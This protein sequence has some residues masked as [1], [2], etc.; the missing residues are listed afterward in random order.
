MRIE[1]G[2]SVEQP[3]P[4]GLTRSDHVRR[5]YAARIRD[6]QRHQLTGRRLRAPRFRTLPIRL[7]VI[8]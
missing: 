1:N 7:T 2:M 8:Y 3:G 6:I 5:V 4:A